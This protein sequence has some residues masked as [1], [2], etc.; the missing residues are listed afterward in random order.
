MVAAP[1]TAAVDF[2][3]LRRLTWPERDVLAFLFISIPP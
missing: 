2:R 3:N 1:A